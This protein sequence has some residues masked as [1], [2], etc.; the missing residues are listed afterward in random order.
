MFQLKC[1]RYRK[2]RLTK[3]KR[4]FIKD[5]QLGLGIWEELYQQVERAWLR[6]YDATGEWIPTLAERLEEIE[7]QVFLERRRADT[8]QQ[9]AEAKQ[10]QVAMERCHAEAERQRAERLA[11]QLRALG[12]KPEW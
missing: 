12:I 5:I 8:E 7:R 4:F 10:Q 3:E 6:W 9:R 2:Q 11:A 1:G